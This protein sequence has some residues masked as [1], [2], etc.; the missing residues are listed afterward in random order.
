[1]KGRSGKVGRAGTGLVLRCI[2]SASTVEDR[3]HTGALPENA[4]D[5]HNV[6]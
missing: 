2:A 5:E 1:V 3:E 6:E 4:P